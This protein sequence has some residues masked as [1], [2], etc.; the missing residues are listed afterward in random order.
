MSDNFC[1]IAWFA[2]G[3]HT[4][5]DDTAIG[6]M[7]CLIA[8]EIIENGIVM[9]DARRYPV[10]QPNPGEIEKFRPQKKTDFRGYNTGVKP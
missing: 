6:P 9:G 3:L 5:L 1:I 10:I 7:P 8:Q 4:P 2:V